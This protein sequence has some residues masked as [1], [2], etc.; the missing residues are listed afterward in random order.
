MAWE[1]TEQDFNSVGHLLPEGAIDIIQ[2]IGPDAAY[3][4]IKRWGGINLPVGMN[5]TRAGKMLHA[6]LAEEIGEENAG[7]I[8]RVYG[9]QRFL[10]IPKCQDAM[11][12]LR[13]RQ[14]RAKLDIMT[15]RDKLGMP[16]AVRQIAIEYNL[17]DRQVWNI[18]KLPDIEPSPQINLI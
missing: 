18:S 15:M 11:R 6:K 16:E 4:L 1:M 3:Q 2:V 14:I 13:N 7:K 17:T 8:S 5:K 12:E 10:W 9:G